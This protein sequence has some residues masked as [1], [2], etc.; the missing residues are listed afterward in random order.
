MGYNTI[1][2]Y[3]TNAFIN[4]VLKQ[5]EKEGKVLRKHTCSLHG[6]KSSLGFI[7][8]VYLW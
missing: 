1:Q 3:D 6:G 8:A 5:S 4:Y 7:E 2:M